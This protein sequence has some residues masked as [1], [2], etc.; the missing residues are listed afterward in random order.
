MG[1]DLKDSQFDV[2]VAGG[3]P[4]GFGAAL[5]AA[6]AGARVAVVE[7]HPI[8]GGMGTAALVNNFIGARLDQDTFIVGGVFTQLRLRLMKR[9]AISVDAGA[10]CYDPDVCAVEMLAMC[11]ESDVRVYFGCGIADVAFNSPGAV[12]MMLDGQEQATIAGRTIV[13]ATGDAV[14]SYKA[15]V[16]FRFGRESDGAVMPVTYCYMIGPVDIEKLQAVLPETVK[17]DKGLN[18]KKIHLG[19]QPAVVERFRRA[20]EAGDLAELTVPIALGLSIPGRPQYIT[21]NFNRIHVKDPTD[22]KQLA[23]AEVKGRRQIEEGIR[24][25]RKYFPGFESAELVRLGRQIGVRE[26]RHIEGLYTLTAE[27][28]LSARQFDDVIAQTRYPIDIHDPNTNTTTM[29]YLPEG[30]HYD[31]PWRCLVPKAGPPNLIVAG[32]CLS[33]T[34]EAASS[35]RASAPVMAIGEAAGVTAALAARQGVA[36]AQVDYHEVQKRLK[37][38]GAIL[39]DPRLLPTA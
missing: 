21:L 35:A 29:T 5:G 6:G 30:E 18:E 20:R 15:G 36:I 1:D 31:I 38:N 24:F 11:D 19:G 12:T 7:R 2:I 39:H 22:P 4:A 16:P 17:F 25:L 14:I 33:A 32:R 26:S 28:V 13:D 10:L 27:D 9:R 8:L 3:G 37:E 23:D 34:H